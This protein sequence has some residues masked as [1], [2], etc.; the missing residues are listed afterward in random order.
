M[1]FEGLVVGLRVPDVTTGLGVGFRVLG[2]GVGF[3]VDGFGVGL[4]V[5]LGAPDVTTLF[6]QVAGIVASSAYG[7]AQCKDA[8][9][10]GQVT[11]SYVTVGL[12]HLRLK[13][14]SQP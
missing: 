13:K 9:S 7:C 3:R 14:F 8:S 12:F 6:E 5:G 1:A 11:S 2:L 10:G 4:E